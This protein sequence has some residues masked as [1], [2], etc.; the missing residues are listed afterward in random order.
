MSFSHNLPIVLLAVFFLAACGQEPNVAEKR[1]VPT[2]APPTAVVKKIPRFD[3]DSAYT[4]IAKQVDF[5]PRVVNSQ[6]HKATRKW[7][8]GKLKSF[9][10]EVIEQDFV[11]TA[12]TGEK[13]ASTNI[14]A[15]FEPALTDRILLCAHWDSRHIADSKINTGDKSQPVDGADDGASGVG[16]LLEIAR[17]LGQASPGIGVDI[18][19]LDAEDYGES[20]AEDPNSWGLGAQYYS[21]NMPTSVKPR[22]GILLDMVGAKN[23]RFGREGVSERFAPQLLDKVWKLA[24]QMGYGN[25]FVDDQTG[26]VTDDHYFINSIA[27][28]P[29][30]DIINRPAGSETGFVE[31]WHTDHDNME[32]I[33]RGTLRAVGQLVLALVYREAAGTI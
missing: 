2:T 24:K 6:A 18:I 15:Q 5:G 9:G 12:Y 4:Y 25:Y 17:Q 16:V 11:A 28:I 23:A 10:A 3:R 31:H 20:G 8:V 27:G 33:D 19:F 29:T 22:Y 21:R 13:L 1:S 14:I 26:G 30:I 32:I 7:L